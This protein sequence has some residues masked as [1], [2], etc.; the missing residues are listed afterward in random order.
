MKNL[1]VYLRIIMGVLFLCVGNMQAWGNQTTY[2]GRG[3]ATVSSASPTGAGTVYVSTTN[4]GNGTYANTSNATGSASSTG[5]SATVTVYAFARANDNYEF[6]GWNSQNGTTATTSTNN[7]QNISGVANSTNENNPTNIGTLY[8]IFAAKPVFYFS[9]TA[10]ASPAGGGTASVS[11]ATTNV[12][13]ERWNSTSATTT[14]TFT[15]TPNTGYNFL[16]W[17]TTADGAVVSTANPYSATLTSTST[18]SGSPTNTTLYAKFEQIIVPSAISATPSTISICAG[19]NG[20]F[21]YTL[22]PS[23]AYDNVIVTSGNTGIATVSKTGTTIT[24]TSVAAGSTTV[25]LSARDYLDVETAST[26]VAVTVMSYCTAPTIGGYDNATG[27]VTIT[28]AANTTVY[29]T[30]DGSDPTDGST[31]YSAPF[32][33]TEPATV[34]A[35]AY[36]DGYCPSTVTSR[37][38]AKVAT[39]TINI[40]DAGVTFSGAAGATYYYSIGGG[41]PTTQWDGSTPITGLSEGDVIKVMAKQAGMIN[42]DVAT[43]AYQ[44]PSGVSGTNVILNDREDHAWS[45]YSDPECPIRSLSPADVK[46]TYYGDGIVMTGNADYTASSTDFVQPGNGNY[47]GGASV[48]VT[49]GEDQNTFIYYKTLERGDATQTAWTFSSGNQSSAASRCPYTTIPNP[50]QVRPTY[51]TPPTSNRAAWTGWRGFQCWRLKSVSGGA[52]Y[53]AASGGTALALNAIINAETEIYFAPNSEYG[54]EVEL[55]AV[56]AIAYLVYANGNGSW[57]VPNHADLGYERNFVVLSSD[58]D[59]YFRVGN[60][61]NTAYIS[62]INRPS[63]IT[64]YLPNGTSGNQQIGRVRGEY[65]N[66][67]NNSVI[68]LQANTKFENVQFTNLTGNSNT[69]TAAGY[70]L[71]VGRG[72]TSTNVGTVRGMSDG[73]TSAVNYTIRLESGTFGTFALIDNTAR[74]FSSTI[75]TRAVFGSDY[76]RAKSDNSKLSIAAS[77]TIYGGNAAHTFS[78]SANRNNITYDWLIKSGRVQ[79]STSVGDAAADKS[80]YIGNSISG[81]NANSIQYCGKRRLTM[82]GGEIASIAG[83]VNCYGNNYANYG[84]N[85]G[86]WSVMIRLKGGTVRGSIYGAAAYAGASGD[87]LFLFTGGTVNGWVAGGANGTQSDGGM[88]YGSSSIYIGGNTSVNSNSSTSVI[89]RA[90]GGNVFG[91]GCGYGAS[92]NSGQVTEGTTVVVADEAYVERGVYGGGSYGYTTSTSTLYVSGGH[93]EGKNGGVSGTSY[94]ASITGGVF[95]GACQ[96]QGGTVNIT[97]TDGLVEGGVYGGSNATGTISG[98][99]TMQID[100]GQVG[101]DASHT[102]NIHG[103]GYGANTAVNGNVSVTLGASTSATDSVTV[104]GNVFGGSALGSV[105]GTTF[106]ASKHTSVTINQGLING[107]LFGGALG[108]ASPLIAAPVNGLITVTI[109]GGSVNGNVYGGGDASAYSSGQNYPVVNMTGG[110]VTNLFGGGKGSTATVTGNPKVT[111]S[112]NAHVTGNVYGGGDAAQVSGETNVILRD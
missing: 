17:S 69:I 10:V 43:A 28:P 53:S 4:N 3:T 101:A 36:R 18:N 99:V 37:T 63:T 91:A 58:K 35:I 111:L 52:V 78:G 103:G 15:A 60:G 12:R 48:N 32:D 21:T 16:G 1:R 5:E 9:A 26:T 44:V 2:Y 13:G 47:V 65:A 31:A 8:A 6:V 19:D 50:F 67:N 77:S 112:G 45:Y 94:S 66:N 29:Y 70:N 88:M 81:N 33:L 14:A 85:D 106:D 54:M 109:N 27:K 89:N 97:M 56:W 102:A 68:T 79:G 96:N 24:V 80:I 7:P 108:Q 46:I 82:E 59:F 98:N 11:P 86:T 105:N 95:G 71:I 55:E 64:P 74:T 92:S 51:G 104:Y 22:T 20:T 87:R 76:D 110:T 72:C 41:D 84:V 25:T 73:S 83:S 61:N 107:N 34:K 90:V 49:T 40:D 62:D 42:S 75:S 93:V 23:N 39:P 100:G 38:V 30:T 57:S